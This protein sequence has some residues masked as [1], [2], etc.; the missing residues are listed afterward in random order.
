MKRASKINEKRLK[1]FRNYIKLTRKWDS[2]FDKF[3]K[4]HQG[5]LTH[6]DNEDRER[7]IEMRRKELNEIKIELDCA[8]MGGIHCL[9][10]NGLEYVLKELNIN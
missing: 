4:E 7:Y 1:D 10:I 5:H 8:D 2:T 9:D 3:Y 6:K